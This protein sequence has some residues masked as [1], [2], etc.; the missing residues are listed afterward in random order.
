[1]LRVDRPLVGFLCQVVLS[2]LLQEYAQVERRSRGSL[3]MLRVDRLLI[4][5]HCTSVLALPIKDKTPEI[6]CPRF[7]LSGSPLICILSYRT[8]GLAS[9]LSGRFFSPLTRFVS[10]VLNVIIA[11]IDALLMCQTGISHIC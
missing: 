8:L 3:R 1:M 4:S 6:C 2:D 5:F 9:R 10:G 7:S 11:L